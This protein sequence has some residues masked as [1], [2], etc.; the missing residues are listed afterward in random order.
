MSPFFESFFRELRRPL[1]G[2]LP[3]IVIVMIALLGSS[4]A[5]AVDA[6]T[7]ETPKSVEL[8]VAPLDQITYPEDRP[9][10]LGDPPT[11]DGSV[12]RWVVVSTPAETVQQSEE[13]LRLM[14]HAAVSTYVRG[15]VDA[16]NQF[17]FFP[18]TDRWIDEQL[19]RR[20]YDGEVTQGDLLLHEHATELVFDPQTKADIR[21][22][23]KQVQV[24]D[25][26]AVMGVTVAGGLCCLVLGSVVTGMVGRRIKPS[27]D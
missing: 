26:L 13:D 11:R 10:W 21:K 1:R 19:V 3:W 2:D 8:S 12:D 24:R 20:S 14:Q 27:A 17:D 6:V 7:Q 23:W 9:D 16:G 5:K 4:V 18:V 25:R 15:L 22:A